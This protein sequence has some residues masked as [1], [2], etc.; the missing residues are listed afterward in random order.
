[1]QYLLFTYEGILLHG[2]FSVTRQQCTRR[3]C[4]RAAE[5]KNHIASYLELTAI[6][7]LLLHYC[8]ADR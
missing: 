3:A 7:S 2:S 1:M 8:C 4:S 6:F 5:E